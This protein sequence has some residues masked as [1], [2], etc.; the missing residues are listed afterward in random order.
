MRPTG[1][2]SAPLYGIDSHESIM[3]A[4]QACSVGRP[5][6]YPCSVNLND[7]GN[8]RLWRKVLHDNLKTLGV[9]T[10]G[11]RLTVASVKEERRGGRGKREVLL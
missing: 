4:A 3:V 9:A 5:L 1:G 2:D 6:T 8:G 7:G 10:T 11:G